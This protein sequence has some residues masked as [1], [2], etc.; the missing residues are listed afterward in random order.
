MIFSCAAEIVSRR[1]TM[2]P[3]SEMM[4]LRPL[5]YLRSIASENSPPFPY[6]PK[7]IVLHSYIPH[8]YLEYA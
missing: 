3:T 5:Q 7:K 1:H 2:N 6:D 4:A 8:Y